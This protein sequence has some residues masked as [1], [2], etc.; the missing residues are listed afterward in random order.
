M[1]KYLIND[2]FVNVKSKVDE[3]LEKN[4]IHQFLNIN[5]G[6]YA[7]NVELEDIQYVV[8]GNPKVGTLLMQDDL[9]LSFNLPLKLLLIKR[10]DKTEVLYEKPTSWLKE[11]HSDRIKD[12]L[13]KMDNLYL[14]IIKYLE[15]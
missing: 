11:E 14:D 8:F 1:E 10:E 9:Y 15:A 13:P 7:K 4:N 12:I 5:Q 2:E 3:Y 6:E